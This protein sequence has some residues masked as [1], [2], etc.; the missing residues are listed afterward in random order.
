MIKRNQDIR[1][2]KGD[3]PAWLIAEKIGIHEKTFY[4]WLRFE[5]ESNRKKKV[6]AAIKEIKNELK[7]VN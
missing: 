6:L 4:G 7:E 1:K 3:I 5:M 2:A